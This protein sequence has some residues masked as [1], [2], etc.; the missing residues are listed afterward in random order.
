MRRLGFLLD[1]IKFEHTV[2]AL[3]FAL[4][5]L[6]L[7]SEGMPSLYTFGW[8]L[9]AMVGAR[10]TAMTMNRIADR[11]IDAAN[12][13][14]R[15]R[16]LPAGRI[17]LGAA[18]TLA[19]VSAAVFVV[20]AW[21]LNRL[22]FVLSPVALAVVWSY[23][24]TKR[25]TWASH[26]WLGLSLALAPLGA[27]I[28]V[29]GRLDGLPLLLGLGVLFWV[30]GF[31]TIYACQDVDTDRRQG[32]YSLPARLG[33]RR[34]LVVARVFHGLMLGVFTLIGIAFGF[35]WLYA[36]G[37]VCTGVL[38]IVQ[39]ALVRASDLRHIEVAFFNVNSIVGV[40][41]MA[42]TLADRFLLR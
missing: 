39:H 6:F 10:S 1:M 25:F 23:S 21:R 36:I 31:D 32:L 30:A 27:W 8:V 15:E 11:H 17:G 40:V 33:P 19:L 2:F 4:L 34:A 7:A 28:A 42:F 3:P 22:A 18:W 5:A 13:R 16:H 29:R 14:T 20:A 38:V 9:V 24:W 26:L 35:G 41:L 37:L 12:P